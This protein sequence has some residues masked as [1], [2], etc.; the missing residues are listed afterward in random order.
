MVQPPRVEETPAEAEGAE[1][2]EG[3][4][5][6]KPAEGAEGDAAKPADGDAKPDDKKD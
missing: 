5:G 4:E 3:E 2:A 6:E 1:G